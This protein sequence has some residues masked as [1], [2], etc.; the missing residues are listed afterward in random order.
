MRHA[1][2]S[3]FSSAGA[4]DGTDLW[5]ILRTF[6]ATSLTMPHE[7]SPNPYLHGIELFNRG[8][9]FDAHEVWED[10]WRS[11]QGDHRMFYQGLIQAAVAMEHYRRGNARSAATVWRNSRAKLTSVPERMEGLHVPTFVADMERALG[12]VLADVCDNG[13]G[14]TIAPFDPTAAPTIRVET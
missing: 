8:E 7:P 2:H 3:H 12:P 9:Y 14:R 1:R 11:S 5:E 6:N 4:G 10:P 13:Q